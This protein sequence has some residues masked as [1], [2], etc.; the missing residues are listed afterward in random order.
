MVYT[1]L[2]LSVDLP[3][4]TLQSA[5]WATPPAGLKGLVLSTKGFYAGYVGSQLY[6]SESFLAYAWPTDYAID[7]T[8][9]ISHI[10]RYGDMLAVFTDREIALIVGNNPLEVRKIKVEGFELLTS[11]YSTAELDGLLYFATPTGL[12]VLSGTNAAIVTDDVVAERW[13]RDNINASECRVV[14]F[15][16][17]VYLLA[18]PEGQI[19]R[20]G[21]R[22]DGGGFVRLSDSPIRDLYAS[23]FFRGVVL[24]PNTETDYYIFNVGADTPRTAVWRSRVEVADIPMAVISVRVLADAYPVTFRIYEGDDPTPVSLGGVTEITLDNDKIRK[25]P[26]MR[27]GREWSF[28]VEGATNIASLEIGTSGRVR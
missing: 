22:E 28:E 13:W 25:L 5:D 11:I 1:D 3:G 6:L 8:G 7:F 17:V 24:L 9:D 19:Y 20:M 21:L 23:S 12:A 15:D 14:A 2:L 27:R 18:E 4:D 10:A 26:V 16:N